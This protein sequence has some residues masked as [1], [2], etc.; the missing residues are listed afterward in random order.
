MKEF[1]EIIVIFLFTI[2]FFIIVGGD[3]KNHK[4]K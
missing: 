1:L 3:K 4:N 2:V